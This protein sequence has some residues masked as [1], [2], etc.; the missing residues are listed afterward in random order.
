MIFVIFFSDL[1][2]SEVRLLGFLEETD[3]LKA[4]SHRFGHHYL[5]RIAYGI[6]RVTFC[7]FRIPSCTIFNAT[8]KDD[9]SIDLAE[10]MII[11]RLP[12]P[13]SGSKSSA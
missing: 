5:F 10:R 4:L 7:I 13:L 8:V 1:S 9:I 12:L 6:F 11:A 2:C 3:I